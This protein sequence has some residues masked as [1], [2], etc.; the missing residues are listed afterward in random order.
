MQPGERTMRWSFSLAY[1]LNQKNKGF[2]RSLW[3]IS[4]LSLITPVVS[5]C[6]ANAIPSV[7]QPDRLIPLGEELAFVRLSDPILYNRYL[8]YPSIATRNDFI[9]A[10]MYA[11]DVQYTLYESQLTHENQDVN[12]IATAVNLGLTGTASLIPVA[13]TSRLLAGIA[14]GVTGLDT[15][16]N[17]KILLSKAIQNIQTQMRANRNDQAAIILANMKCDQQAYPIGMAL[18]DLEAY[19][20]AGTFTA[21]ILNLTNTVN[22]AETD[23]KANKES[24]SPAPPAAAVMQLRM[25]ANIANSKANPVT[26][27]Q[28]GLQFDR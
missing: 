11:I 1:W 20:R 7:R 28:R 14:T 2:I 12:F 24:Q 8:N 18:S 26:C 23:A 3:R 27:V 21:G 19:Y 16:Y 4:W 25:T 13:Q 22:K 9:T 10:R 5:G 17:E 15:A 6:W